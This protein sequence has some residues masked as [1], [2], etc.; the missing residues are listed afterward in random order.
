MTAH[1]KVGTVINACDFC[2]FPAA[3][4][5]GGTE[6]N[7]ESISGH[8]CSKECFD[9]WVRWKAALLSHKA[10]TSA[11]LFPQQNQKEGQAVLP[12]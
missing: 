6:I 10:V 9:S 12:V 1:R 7:G 4:H 2:G 11:V 5:E 8:F 3:D